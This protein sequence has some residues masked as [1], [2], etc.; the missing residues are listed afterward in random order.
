VAVLFGYYELCSLLLRDLET[1]RRIMT[2]SSSSKL[3]PLRRAT[4][5]NY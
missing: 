4:T 1:R 5:K 2:S 3:P